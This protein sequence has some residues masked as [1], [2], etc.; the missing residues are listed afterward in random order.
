MRGCIDV[1][2]SEKGER[3]YYL[4]NLKVFLVILVIVHHVGQAYGPTGGFWHYQSSLGESIPALGRFFAVNAGFFMGFLFLISGYFF[5]MSYDRNNGKSFL[6]KRLLRFGIPLLFVFLIIEPVQMYFYY[7]VYSG[8]EPLSFFQYYAK[9]WFGVGGMPEGFIDSIDRFPHLN[10]GYAWFIQHLLVY[11]I[12][13]WLFRKIF[14]KPILKQESKP[15]TALHMFIIF[16][17]IAVSSL[18]VRIWYPIDYWVGLLGFFQVE[19]AHWPQY[20]V[21]FVV[22]IIAYR[23]N[24]LNTLSIKTGYTSLLIAILLAL[25]VYIGTLNALYGQFE[26]W[27]KVWAIYES[28]LAVTMV[29]G[30][31]TLFREIGNRTTPFLQTLSRSSFAAYIFHMPIVL[32]VQYALD[33]VVIGGAIGKFIIVSVI[34]VAITYALCAFLVRVKPLGKI[35]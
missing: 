14:K 22:G 28:L 21:M 23:K 19:I 3:F 5:P 2:K 35:L 32:T 10:F 11:A 30:L 24:W 6:Q 26:S 15:F 7:T 8:N 25:G 34:S 17:T 12:F 29:F 4:D 20:L 27:W 1:M 16:I 31:L 18:I 33:T 9:I 13:Y